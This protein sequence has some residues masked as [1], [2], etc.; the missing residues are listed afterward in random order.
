MSSDPRSLR[1]SVDTRAARICLLLSSPTVIRLQFLTTWAL[2]TMCPNLETKKPEP[3]LDCGAEVVG[4]G[5]GFGLGGTGT[6][7]DTLGCDCLGA[8]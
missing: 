6:V 2:V 7:L 3:E 1:L 4:I 8:E 5:V